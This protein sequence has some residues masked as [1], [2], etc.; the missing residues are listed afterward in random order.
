MPRR[1]PPQ[2]DLFD[3]IAQ[4]R[5]VRPEDRTIYCAV[6]ALRAAGFRVYRAGRGASLVNGRRVPNVAL[7]TVVGGLA[8]GSAGQ[9]SGRRRG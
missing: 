7:L 5:A 6:L 8:A 3:P 2:P 1:P 9:V 4:S